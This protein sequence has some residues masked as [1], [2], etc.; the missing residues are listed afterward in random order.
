MFVIVCLTIICNESCLE[1]ETIG[2]IIV[3]RQ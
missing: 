1:T 2:D 3:M